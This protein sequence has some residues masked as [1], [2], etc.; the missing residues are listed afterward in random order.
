MEQLI[1]ITKQVLDILIQLALLIVPII[2]S[3][4]IYTY[5]RSTAAG[6]NVAAIVRLANAAIDYIENLDKRGDLVVGPD[7]KKGGVK[8]KLAANWLEQELQ[9][10]GI[11]I[12][13]EQAQKWVAA[14]FQ[15]RVGDIR[16]VAA[17]GEVTRMAVNLIQDLERNHFITLPP[18]VERDAHLAVLASDWVVTQ[19]AKGG[20]TVSRD[21]AMTWVRA[22]LL[23]RLQ[24]QVSVL[25]AG[26]RL[27]KLAEG[28]VDFLERLKAS[29][30]IAVR[31]GVADEDIETDITTAWLLTEAAQQGLSVSSSQ[32]ARAAAEALRKRAA[33]ARPL[34]ITPPPPQPQ[35]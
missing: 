3:W 5:V 33:E 30:Q 15:K 25:P 7:V 32:I 20:V 19:L 13:D 23:Q 4:F 26:E 28:A 24:D 8:L 17:F 6:N 9:K 31:P 1:P 12:D 14:E 16:P 27:T 22:E 35:Q 34:V 11:K 29:G 21:E 10:S 18:N 2:I